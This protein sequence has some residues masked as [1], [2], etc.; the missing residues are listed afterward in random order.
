MKEAVVYYTFGGST[1]KEAERIGAELGAP[2]FRVK[3]KWNRGLI[4]AFVPG[5]FQAIKRKK[6]KLEPVAFNL[7]EYDKIY[8]G[9]PIWA[10]NPAPAFNS[11]VE[12]LPSGK[13]VEVFFCA[14]GGDPRESDEQ[15]KRMIEQKGCSVSRLYTITTGKVPGKLK[16]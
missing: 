13:E 6:T 4:G 8:L 9:A 16:E 3:E 1:K 15:T 11:M 10:S 12:L 14:A 5:G 7:S 2:V